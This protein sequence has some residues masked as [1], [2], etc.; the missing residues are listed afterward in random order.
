M[1]KTKTETKMGQI[2]RQ[3]YHPCIDERFRNDTQ[4]QKHSLTY[5][6]KKDHT[7]GSN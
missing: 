1:T 5:Y 3:I 7:I 2:G 4:T 6:W